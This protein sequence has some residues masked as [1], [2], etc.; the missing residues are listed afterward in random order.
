MCGIHVW[1]SEVQPL[2]LDG[3]FKSLGLAR[4]GFPAGLQAGGPHPTFAGQAD[5]L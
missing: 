5:L 2:S 3:K 4:K 1:P